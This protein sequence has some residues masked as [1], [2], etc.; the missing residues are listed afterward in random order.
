M[1]VLKLFSIILLIIVFSGCKYD[2]II[3]EDIP[4]VN[5]DDPNVAEI[6]FL[7][8][9]IPIFNDNNNCTACHKTG[10]QIPD[11]T[12]DHAYASLNSTRY[13]NSSKPEESRIYLHPNP[14]TST[15]THKKYTAAEAATILLWI[16]QGAKNN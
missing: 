4:V 16:Q 8:D 5:P 3:P 7:N 13:I 14:K 11:L 9:I 1:K 12:P 15:H 6:S 10:G 2:F